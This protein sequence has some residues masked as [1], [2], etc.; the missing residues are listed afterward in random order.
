[1]FTHKATPTTFQWTIMEIFEEFIPRFMKV[2]LDNFAVFSLTGQHLECLRKCL[3]CCRD[4]NLKLNPAKCAFAVSDGRLIGQIVSKHG[5]AIE[6]VCGL[7][8]A[9]PNKHEKADAV[10][11]VGPLA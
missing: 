9:S 6:C 10:P 2:F 11:R 3:Q 8:R 4:T 5:I 7:V 1:M